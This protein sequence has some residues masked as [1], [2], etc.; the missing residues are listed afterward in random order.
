MNRLTALA[1]RFVGDRLAVDTWILMATTIVVAG[2]S[3][4]FNSIVAHRAGPDAYGAIA[5]LMN[6]GTLAAF[7]SVGVQY[8]VA[9]RVGDGA[10][11]ASQMRRYALKTLWPWT[12][13]A[14]GTLPATLPVAR[15]LRLPDPTA[16]A[17]TLAY[18]LLV[19]S[20]GV[21][22]GILTAQRRFAAYGV[23]CAIAVGLRLALTLAL[24]GGRQPILGAMVASVLGA[25]T[26][27]FAATVSALRPVRG[28]SPPAPALQPG[29]VGLDGVTSGLLS[30]YPWVIF[31]VPLLYVRHR[32]G[33]EVAGDFAAAQLISSSVLFLTS[34]VTTSYYPLISRR[35]DIRLVRQGWRWTVV[36]ALLTALTAILFSPLASRVVY[37]GAF[38]IDT[39]DVAMLATSAV[40]VS[41]AMYV[42]WSAHALRRGERASA[43][44]ISV[45]LLLEG[46]FDLGHP[47]VH[48]LAAAPAVTVAGGAFVVLA[49]STFRS[50][51]HRLHGI[52]SLAP[53][54]VTSAVSPNEGASLLGFTAVG[55]MAHNEAA[56]IRGCMEAL[57][58]ESDGTSSLAKVVVVVSGSTD[59]TAEIALELRSRDPRVVVLVEPNRT[60]KA[61]AINWF[62]R[63]TDEPICALVGADTVPSPG[64]IAE[65]VRPL[66]IPGV[67]MTGAHIVPLNP[68]KGMVNQVVHVLWRLHHEVALRHPKL[69]E[70][71]AFR[72]AF[73]E[74]ISTSLVDETSIEM[75][76]VA[77]GWTLAYAPDAVIYNHGPTSLRQYLAQR[78]RIQSGHIGVEATTGYRASTRHVRLVLAA[79][80]RMARQNSGD[81]PY[82]AAAVGIEAMAR[83]QAFFSYCVR[84]VQKHGTWH[85]M[86]TSKVHLEP[87]QDVLRVSHEQEAP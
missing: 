68:R 44:F 2:G 56:N 24:A 75:L 72:R 5:S 76:V 70:A 10:L 3:I 36:L 31:G 23:V 22:A 59:G 21:P 13:L 19:V 51:H 1:R 71:V 49:A 77:A 32:L 57:L 4:A 63:E 34:P 30:V 29:S 28:P 27:V 9:R 33:G 35:R 73:R 37:G 74:I 64:A 61:S 50:W 54:D 81:I 69:G 39:L 6:A 78:R 65:L 38:T 80:L 40:A 17:L 87:P 47:N 14:V 66:S 58:R 83:T 16:P 18:A 11:T 53:N 46:V 41:I 43:A 60:G 79:V 42:V 45:S 86:T 25:A 55:V 20:L 52:V 84:G 67:G 7:A 82:I 62:L 26:W 15:Y 48:F 12:A 8:A 85:P